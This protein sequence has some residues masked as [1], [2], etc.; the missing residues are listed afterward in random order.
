M[1]TRGMSASKGARFA[2]DTKGRV[3]VCVTCYALPVFTGKVALPEVTADFFPV[4][5]AF[6]TVKSTS[7]FPLVMA[8][9]YALSHGLFDM[10]LVDREGYVSEGA[11]SNVFVVRHGVLYTPRSGILPGVTRDAILR[12]ARGLV[13]KKILKKIVYAYFKKSFVRAADEVFFTNAPSG[14]VS[15]V[16]VGDRALRK[17]KPVPITKAVYSAFLDS[18]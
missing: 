17:G 4:E 2:P 18:L 1:V 8:R 12:I 13:R 9:M 5:R 15:V 6:P 10:L 7:L 16:K 14:V 3:T 11:V